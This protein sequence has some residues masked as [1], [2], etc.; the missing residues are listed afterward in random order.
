MLSLSLHLPLDTFH[1][2]FNSE[3]HFMPRDGHKHRKP[4]HENAE[5]MRTCY[6]MVPPAGIKVRHTFAVPCSL[7][8]LFGPNFSYS[9]TKQ[10]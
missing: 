2:H 6:E 10:N 4:A 5:K 8:P 9:E 7:Y 3:C 1:L